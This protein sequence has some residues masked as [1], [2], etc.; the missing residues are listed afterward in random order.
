MDASSWLKFV[1]M[2]CHALCL[3]LGSLGTSGIPEDLTCVSKTLQLQPCPMTSSR[4]S[5][6]VLVA[7]P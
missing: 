6:E 4:I 5:T 7:Y 3:V 1:S 2:D